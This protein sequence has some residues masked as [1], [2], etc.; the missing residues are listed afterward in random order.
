[1]PRPLVT[2]PPFRA[3][4]ATQQRGGMKAGLVTTLGLVALLPGSAL[5]QSSMV[6]GWDFSQYFGDGFMSIDGGNSF[7]NTLS[8]NYSDLDPTFGAGFESQAFGTMFVDGS[9]GS[10][11]VAAGSGTEEFLPSATAPGSL[12]SNLGAPG[13]VDFDAFSVLE[14]EGQVSQ[15]LLSMLATAPA[16]VVFQADLSSVLRTG[17]DWSLSFGAK[18]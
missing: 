4:G 15:E 6:A 14:D 8:A 5:A 3:W 12:V 1:M 11:N 13:T 17:S 7:T 10:T 16:T 18:M 9:F 2:A